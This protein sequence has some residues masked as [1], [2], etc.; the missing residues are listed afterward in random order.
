M[1][2]ARESR[3]DREWKRARRRNKTA[4]LFTH[5][6]TQKS[7]LLPLLYFVLIIVCMEVNQASQ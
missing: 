1:K 6:M 3:P 7:T 5:P 4:A 2:F